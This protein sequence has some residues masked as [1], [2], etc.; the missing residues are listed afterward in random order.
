[1]TD[2]E[3]NT[4]A[5]RGLEEHMQITLI[6]A[7][8]ISFMLF[9]VLLLLRPSLTIGTFRRFIFLRLLNLTKMRRL[10]FYILPTL[11]F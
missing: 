4:L 6:F 1:M 10:P 9:T 7:S 8:P 5:V 3:M 2:R 11:L